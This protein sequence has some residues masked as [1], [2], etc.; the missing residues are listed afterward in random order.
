MGPAWA[1]GRLS[2]VTALTAVRWRA[3]AITVQVAVLLAWIGYAAMLAATRA[4][5]ASA[6]PSAWWCM[7]G[8]ALGGSTSSSG[9]L[10]A[11]LAGVPMWSL[12]AFAMTLPGAVP[13]A[14]HVA[15]NSLGRRQWRA[16]AEFLAVYLGLWL[17]FGLLAMAALTLLPSVPPA[18][19]LAAALLLAAIWELTPLKR[20]ALDRCHRSSPLPPR[21]LRASA[22]VTRFAWINGSACIGMCWPAMLAM[23]LAPTARLGWAAGFTGL[24]TY[25]K[26]TRRPRRATRRAAA[27]LAAAAIGVVLGLA[28]G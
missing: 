21:G 7:P 10:A 28:L 2:Q 17:A 15:I 19:M 23:L 13:A 16:V 1:S 8:M 25:Q 20:L 11:A 5:P 27:L 22:A 26:L 12:M 9:P 18:R 24:A 4:P 3:P 14:Q 6:G